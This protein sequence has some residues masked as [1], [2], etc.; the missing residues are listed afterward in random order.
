[1]FDCKNLKRSQKESS[2]YTE[3]MLEVEYSASSS[4]SVT[5]VIAL[6]PSVSVAVLAALKK[7]TKKGTSGFIQA[8]NIT[9]RSVDPLHTLW[10]PQYMTNRGSV[11][12]HV[13][14]YVCGWVWHF[15][16]SGQRLHRTRAGVTPLGVTRSL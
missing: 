11:F 8:L 10:P 16:W 3:H 13:R 14:D 2:F 4:A 5:Q 9:R 6:V 15:E 1:V 7:G 12:N